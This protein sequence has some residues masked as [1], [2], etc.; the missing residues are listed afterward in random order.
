MSC[1]LE[2]RPERRPGRPAAEHIAAAARCLRSATAGR[3]RERAEQPSTAG[4]SGSTRRTAGRTSGWRRS[5][6]TGP[7]QPDERRAPRH[8]SEATEWYTEARDLLLSRA[9]CPRTT[10]RRSSSR[11]G[12][13][14]MAKLAKV[15]LELGQEA[16]RK[17]R[18]RLSKS[19]NRRDVL[20]PDA[21]RAALDAA[22]GGPAG[23]GA[24][25]RLPCP[26]R[27]QASS[28]HPRGRG[29]RPGMLSRADPDRDAAVAT[30][31]RCARVG[32]GGR[33]LLDPEERDDPDEIRKLRIRNANLFIHRRSETDPQRP[34]PTIPVRSPSGWMSV[35]SQHSRIASTSSP[36]ET[37]GGSDGGGSDGGIS[38]TQRSRPRQVTAQQQAGLQPVDRRAE[39]GGAAA[40]RRG[41]EGREHRSAPDRSGGEAADSLGADGDRRPAAVSIARCGPGR[42]RSGRRHGLHRSLFRD[43]NRPGEARSSSRFR[44]VVGSA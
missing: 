17:R 39:A 5:P 19:M 10:A 9:G 33:G 12:R 3:L 20:P 11:T 35:A 4:H 18:H 6:R 25:P 29:R 32:P 42:S 31:G 15:C 13:S 26:L 7:P 16:H 2:R 1:P 34:P 44:V 24:G 14:Q 28:R 43:R 40:R 37:G 22:P 27:R 38:T 8:L 23:P 21:R 30:K 36:S 41:P